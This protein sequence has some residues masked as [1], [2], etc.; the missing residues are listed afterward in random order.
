MAR[1]IPAIA[2]ACLFALSGAVPAQETKLRLA[3]TQPETDS[4][5]VALVQFAKLV[6]ERTGGQVR[7][8]VF[9]AGQLGN[10]G[11]I[12]SGT[13]GGVIDFALTGNPFFAGINPRQ[14]ALDL[15]GII[16]S[17]AHAYKVLDGPVGAEIRGELEQYS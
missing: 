5:H 11:A 16:R 2:V 9:P 8:E 6:Q 13:R 15:P 1:T 10:D 3:H 12:L 17:F 4:Q 14:S 7:I